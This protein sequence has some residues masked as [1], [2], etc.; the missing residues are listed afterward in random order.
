VVNHKNRRREEPFSCVMEIIRQCGKLLEFEKRFPNGK[1]VERISISDKII[2]FKAILSRDNGGI[3][4]FQCYRIQQSD[5][6]GPYKG[7]TRLHSSVNMNEVK[8]LATLMSLKTALVNVP[9][10]GGKGGICVD[11]KALSEKE[12]ERLVRKYTNRIKDDLGPDEDIPAPDVNSGPREMAWIYDEYRKYSESARG[13]VTGKPLELGGS[14]GRVQATGF[15]V[16]LITE[17]LCYDKKLVNPAIS[18]E[19]FGNVGQYAAM[20]LF[21]MGFKIVAVSDSRGCVVNQVGLNIT[22]LLAFKH[23]T[24]GVTG[25]PGANLVEH[26]IEVPVDVH[27]PCALGHSINRDNVDSIPRDLKIVVEGANAPVSS[28]AESVLIERG[29]ILAP[30]ILANAGGVVVS[31]YEWVQNR[32]GLYWSEEDVLG[33]MRDKMQAAYGNVVSYADERKI[34]LR[35]AAYC[36]A[37]E[38]IA[39]AIIFRGAQ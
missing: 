19:G 22:D 33:K 13:V 15:G 35:Q 38:K 17:R 9:F 36:L 12:L 10:G 2:R 11:P 1:M 3:G 7:G 23:E 30:D 29:V 32:E 26:I 31:Y 5:V 16:A 27:I 28:H 4:V 34:A 14:L 6:L 37:M 24:G 20:K 18:I 25:F 8:A 39:R 21:E